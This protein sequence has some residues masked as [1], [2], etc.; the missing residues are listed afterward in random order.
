MKNIEDKLVSKDIRPTSMRILVLQYLMQ[1]ESAINLTEL[2]NSFDHV[3]RTTL[4]RT[5]KTFE[6]N[7]LI[8]KIDDGTGA[9]KFA[10]CLE[11]CL[12]KPE[13]IHIHFHCITC[14]ETFCVINTKV[15]EVQ[16]PMDF[17]ITEINMVLKGICQNCKF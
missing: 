13:D 1:K 7:N 17:E 15:P 9:P 10:L 12:C 2:E 5:L 3:D 8:H 11:G 14:K 4:Y 6:K 16:L